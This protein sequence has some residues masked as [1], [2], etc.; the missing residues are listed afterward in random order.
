M[1]GDIAE[2]SPMSRNDEQE[3]EELVARGSFD[4][5]TTKRV[6]FVGYGTGRS[7]RYRDIVVRLATRLLRFLRVEGDPVL[8]I[9]SLLKF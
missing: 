9:S 1:H 6:T 7:V 4:R 8:I 3:A 2:R 5:S